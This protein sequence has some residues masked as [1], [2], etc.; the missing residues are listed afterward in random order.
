MLICFIFTVQMRDII[1]STKKVKRR[2][3]QMSNYSFKYKLHFKYKL[4]VYHL[5]SYVSLLVQV[6][7]LRKVK[8]HICV[9]NRAVSRLF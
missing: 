2:V 7:F 8:I 4:K 5:F 9:W 3:S 1:L 6:L